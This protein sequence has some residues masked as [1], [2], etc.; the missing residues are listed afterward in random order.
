[1]TQTSP[2]LPKGKDKALDKYKVVIYC[3]RKNRD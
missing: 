1:M 2:K 3:K